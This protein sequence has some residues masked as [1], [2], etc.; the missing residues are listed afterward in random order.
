MPSHSEATKQSTAP[1]GAIL[2]GSIGGVATLLILL[3]AL[4]VY[5][6]AKRRTVWSWLPPYDGTGT[7]ERHTRNFSSRETREDILHI[8]SAPSRPSDNPSHIPTSLISLPPFEDTEPG[9]EVIPDSRLTLPSLFSHQP[10]SS[11]TCGLPA[12]ADGFRCEATASATPHTSTEVVID[13]NLQFSAVARPIEHSA[14]TRS[15]TVRRSTSTTSV[16]G[17]METGSNEEMLSQLASLRAE[18]AGLRA[19]QE[20]QRRLMDAPPRYGEGM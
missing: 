11:Q 10:T 20:T 2:G 19:Q 13:G 16:A 18:V 9:A 15:D 4:W 12:S 1:L 8:T 14:S 17:S 3:I 6:R 5:M 7:E